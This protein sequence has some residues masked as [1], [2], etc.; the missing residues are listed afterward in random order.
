[1]DFYNITIEKLMKEPEGQQLLVIDP[2]LNGN[3]A[4]RLSHCCVPNCCTLPVICNN[5]YSIAMY[6]T[7]KVNFGEEL[8][9]DYCSFTENEQEYKDSICLCG[10]AQCNGFYLQYSK[11]HLS[12]FS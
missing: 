4:S 6:T 3:F 1:M 2:I 7:K 5:Q 10:N 8:T 12:S 11:K 9:F